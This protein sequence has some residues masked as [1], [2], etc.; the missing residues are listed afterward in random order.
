MKIANC[1]SLL[2]K[3]GNHSIEEEKEKKNIFFDIQTLFNMIDDKPMD[4][5]KDY[6]QEDEK[7]FLYKNFVLL[8]KDD[9][10]GKP[11]ITNLSINNIENLIKVYNKN[12]TSSLKGKMNNE[13]KIH[14]RLNSENNQTR[15][16]LP[17]INR[18]YH[19]KSISG[20]EAMS[21]FKTEL[22]G[23]RIDK[24]YDNI[25]IYSDNENPNHA[26]QRGQY[27]GQNYSKKMQENSLFLPPIY[28]ITTIDQNNLPFPNKKTNFINV[29]D[30]E[31]IKKFQ[32]KFIF[33]K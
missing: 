26:I 18:N 22:K 30:L 25:K 32:R 28:K 21:L 27:S 2:K 33:K 8:R 5:S 3:K 31:K 1:H 7:L 11:K 9:Q 16:A 13:K 12:S 14:A 23:N 4:H 17:L 19:K 24:N 29:Q 6:N 20:S 10:I 15:L